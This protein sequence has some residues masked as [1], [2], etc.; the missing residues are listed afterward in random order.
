MSP[1]LAE[2]PRPRVGVGAIVRRPDGKVLIG[3][4]KNAPGIGVYQMPGGH[5]EFGED[6][7]RCAERETEEETGLKVRGVKILTVTNSVFDKYG[8]HYVTLIV[9]CEMVDPDAQP[10][11][12]EPEKCE[13]WAWMTWDELR[14][15]KGDSKRGE[16]LFDPVHQVL[17]QPLNLDELR[18]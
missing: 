6:I 4:R 15:L 13:P 10:Q 1:Q 16:I 14:A 9:H 12:M 17:E 5:L 3:K 8:T 7:L 2:E 18:P 11:T